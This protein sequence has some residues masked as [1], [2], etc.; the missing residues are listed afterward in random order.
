M[1]LTAASFLLLPLLSWSETVPEY[2]VGETAR[3]DV[4]VPMRLVVIDSTATEKLR[5]KETNRAP[6]LFR[7]NLASADEAETALKLALNDQR[8][9]FLDSVEAVFNQRQVSDE[10]L[11]GDRFKQVVRVFQRQNRNFPLLPSLARAWAVDEGD[12][13]L[14]AQWVSRLRTLQSNYIRAEHLP[15]AGKIGPVRVMAL[16][17]GQRVPELA[18]ALKLAADIARTKLVKLTKAREEVQTAFAEA[19][20]VGRFLAGFVRENCRFE[21]ELTLTN[22]ARRTQAVFAGDPYEPGQ[23]LVKS[24]DVVTAKIASALAEL[25]ARTVVDALKNEAQQ[26][27]AA[28]ANARNRPAQS[29]WQ[30]NDVY[31]WITIAACG[32]V[33]IVLLRRLRSRPRESLALTAQDGGLPALQK[34][35]EAPAIVC[36]SCSQTIVLSVGPAESLAPH[37]PS[38]L[39]PHLAR[40]LASKLFRKLMWQRVYLV[41][42]Q[43]QA[44]AEIQA[45]EERL[46]RARAPIEERLQA[47][48]NRVSELERQLVTAK[49]ETRQLIRT[50]ISAL[51]KKLESERAKEPDFN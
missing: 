29:F 48:E 39:M 49:E 7:F 4:V 5:E 23:T 33:G 45:L 11:E 34:S 17:P 1:A 13:Y 6:A 12:H 43:R 22:R 18:E 50:Q 24:G 44:E 42:S 9:K 21:E 30:P 16:K 46:A 38:S 2:T 40:A 19:P 35:S 31:Q 25:K 20:A 3:V 8:R 36:P 41:E 27:R 32:I 10:R 47:Y 51:H 15:V 14:E 26:A 28:L 37:A